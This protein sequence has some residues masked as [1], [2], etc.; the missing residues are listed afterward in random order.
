M[1]PPLYCICLLNYTITFVG[2]Q[3]KKPQFLA[4]FKKNFLNIQT[5]V[6]LNSGDIARRYN[7]KVIEDCAQSYM[8]YYPSLTVL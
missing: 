5:N 4:V 1:T 8:C 6:L 3:A 2:L 7:L